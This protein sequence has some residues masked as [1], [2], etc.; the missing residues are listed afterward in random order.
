MSTN[1]N[2]PPSDKPQGQAGLDAP[3]GSGHVKHTPAPWKAVQGTDGE[4][5]RWLVVAD[6]EM[7][8]HIAVIENGQPGDCCA[9][10]G[11]TARLIA[12]APELLNALKDIVTHGEPIYPADWV[13]MKGCWTRRTRQGECPEHRT[14]RIGAN[15]SSCGICK[16]K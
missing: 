14:K 5:E 10:E 9:T 3:T 2:L 7:Q 12:A 6:G 15:V 16:T 11:A 13:R 4:P 8:Y 1:E